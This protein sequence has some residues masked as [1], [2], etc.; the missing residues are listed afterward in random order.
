MLLGILTPAPEESPRPPLNVGVLLLAAQFCYGASQFL[1]R[2]SESPLVERG[3][4]ELAER[5]SQQYL[6]SA[7]AYA[8]ASAHRWKIAGPCDV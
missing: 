7:R 1:A 5:D 2:A 6:A 4:R 3:L 8:A